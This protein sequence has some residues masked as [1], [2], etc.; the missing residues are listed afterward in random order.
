MFTP[1]AK[2][3]GIDIAKVKILNAAPNLIEQMLVQGQADAITQFMS[4]R[5]AKARVVAGL[6]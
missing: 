2:L 4:L 6:K 5:S 1:L 3:H